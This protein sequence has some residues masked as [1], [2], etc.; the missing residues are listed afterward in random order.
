M[1]TV[2]H[3]SLLLPHLDLKRIWQLYIIRASCYLTWISREYGNCTSYEPLAT[4]PGS[5]ENMATV[6]HTSLLLPHLDL[7][8]IWQL[9]IIRASCYLTWISREYGNCTSYEPLATSPGS[10]E[11]M[12]T[13]HHTSLLLPH[14]DLKRI[15]QLYIIRA[16]CYLT[17]I[18]REYGNCTS[19]EPLA[20][21]PGSQENMATVHH[22]SLLLP[23]LDLKRIWQLYI[24]RASCYLTWI[25]REYGNCTSYE[26]LATSPGS[27]ENM[28]TVHH[29]SLLL[30]H[31]DLFKEQHGRHKFVIHEAS[32]GT[33]IFDEFVWVRPR[34]WIRAN[35][36]TIIWNKYFWNLRM[37]NIFNDIIY[38]TLQELAYISIEQELWMNTSS[39][40]FN[41][42][43][44]L[45]FLLTWHHHSSCNEYVLKYLHDDEIWIK[46]FNGYK[47]EAFRLQ[48]CRVF[49]D[50][51]HMLPIFSKFFQNPSFFFTPYTTDE[52]PQVKV[53]REWEM[54]H[55]ALSESGIKPTTCSVTSMSQF[56]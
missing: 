4:S 19:Y 21:S 47:L 3:T 5:Q 44:H 55:L 9:Y 11:N 17:W 54:I 49:D 56:L 13:V 26:P 6:H 22:T 35:Q 14:L 39:S 43:D 25:S 41:F 27:Q 29:T 12:A 36:L 18:S 50:E 34:L 23:H 2:H 8:R 30:P 20:T 40:S 52:G 15:W 48:T 37:K 7:K 53:L 46:C 1:A 32:F 33:T 10:Q 31:L 42:R 28:A 16:S 45:V 51:L 24:I 38:D